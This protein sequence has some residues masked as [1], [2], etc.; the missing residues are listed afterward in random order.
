MPILLGSILIPPVRTYNTSIVLDSIT[1]DPA[2]C[3]DSLT[4]DV[5]VTNAD[6]TGPYPTGPFSI[7]DRLTNN[8]LATGT[9][10][11][12]GV[13][14]AVCP[15][16]TGYLEIYAKFDGY[17]QYDGYDAYYFSTS[18]SEIS[19]FALSLVPTTIS[20]IFP[21]AG[22][23][24]CY[25]SETTVIAEVTAGVRVP[26]T[27]GNVNFRLY[28][29]NTNYIQLE[30]ASLDS[31]GYATTTIPANTTTF[32]RSNYLFASFDGYGCYIR[33]QT[34]KG[35]SG[36]LVYPTSND[37]TSLSLSVDGG[38]TFI[39]ANPVIFI[40]TVTA[41]NLTDPSDGYV[42]FYAV[43]VRVSEAIILGNATPINGVASLVVPG[44]T[45][46][47]AGTWDLYGQYFTDGYCYNTSPQV[48]IRINPI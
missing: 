15:S 1:P 29:D 6:V 9:L 46:D 2:S 44:G 5:T 48:N 10:G 33:S 27:D 25:Q 38:S 19:E 47:P 43:D 16:A 32:G 14:T 8:T 42:N 36:L 45:F 7:I 37:T 28:T 21:S 24:Y 12:R 26:V 31:F 35:T 23:Y 11:A 39:A 17:Y 13:G 20:I 3:G 4:F 40:G 34:S 18:T 30:S 41:N 22:D